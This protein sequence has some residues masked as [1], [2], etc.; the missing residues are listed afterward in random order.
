MVG[1]AKL[2]AIVRALAKVSWR[3]IQSFSSITGQNFL[4]FVILVALQ[5]QSAEF[6]LVLLLLVLFFPLASDAM[7]KIPHDRR[8]SWPLSYREWGLVRVAAL[9]LSPIA[10][11][12][13]LLFFRTGIRTGLLAA[14]FGIVL[15]LLLSQA[16]R[17]MKAGGTFWMQWIPRPPGIIGSIMRLHWREMLSTLDP[18]VALVLMLCAVAFRASGKT[19]DPSAP[20]ILSLLVCLALSTQPQVLLALD[21][22]GASR[23]EQWPLKGWQILLAKDLAFLTILALLVAPLGFLSGFFGGIAAL[24]IGH[25]RSVM[26]PTTQHRWRFTSGVLLPDGMVQI[27]VLFGVGIQIQTHPLLLITVSLAAWLAS[28]CFFGWQ[29]DRRRF[30]A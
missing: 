13:F 26:P 3:D 23:Y 24:A 14:G 15:Q 4:V 12:L 22:S 18:Y 1:I 25:R 29:W 20:Q 10:W 6:F 8:A 7:A 2:L 16:K 27:A 19:L 5:T 11:L 30:S 17:Y 21:G 28:T 9:A